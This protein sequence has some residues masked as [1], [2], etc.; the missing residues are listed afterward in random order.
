MLSQ[1]TW[2]TFNNLGAFIETWQSICMWFR[3]SK[4]TFSIDLLEIKE[5]YRTSI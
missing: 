1:I 3:S 2:K 5:V 4:A